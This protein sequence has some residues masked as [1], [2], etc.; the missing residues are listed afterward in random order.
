LNVLPA[1]VRLPEKVALPLAP[2]YRL[3]KLAMLTVSASGPV[4]A[5]TPA[6]TAEMLP[7]DIQAPM[8]L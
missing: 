7:L 6:E 1:G 3:G 5:R 4:S 8:V 2:M